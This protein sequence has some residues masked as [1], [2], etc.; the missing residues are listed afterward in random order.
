MMNTITTLSAAALVATFAVGCSQSPS[1]S[2]SNPTFGRIKTDQIGYETKSAKIAIIPDSASD[3]FQ[4]LDIQDNVVY[5]GVT[6]LADEWF[7]SGTKVKQADFS[8]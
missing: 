2:A 7:A 1:D 8:D 3:A 5:E 6:S 4:I